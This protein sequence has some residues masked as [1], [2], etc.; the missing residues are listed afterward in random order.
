MRNIHASY[1]G[2]ILQIQYRFQRFP[3]IWSPPIARAECDQRYCQYSN[4]W[5]ET[6]FSET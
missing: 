4:K 3:R 2:L 5:K 6:Q 1:I